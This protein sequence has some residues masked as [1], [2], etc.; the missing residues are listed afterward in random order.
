M[1][2]KRREMKKNGKGLKLPTYKQTK[3]C[4]R[5]DLVTWRDNSQGLKH[6]TPQDKNV[7]RMSNWPILNLESLGQSGW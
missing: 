2:V 1:E 3:A 4:K 5:H 6:L 7:G